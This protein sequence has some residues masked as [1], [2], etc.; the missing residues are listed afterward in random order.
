MKVKGTERAC[1]CFGYRS[2]RLGECLATAGLRRHGREARRAGAKWAYIWG[3]RRRDEG[4]EEAE[5]RAQENASGCDVE[6][7]G[8][9]CRL[10]SAFLCKS[11]EAH[12]TGGQV[13]I[14]SFPFARW[15][16]LSTAQS[17]GMVARSF[18]LARPPIAAL[19]SCAHRRVAMAHAAWCKRRSGNSADGGLTGGGGRF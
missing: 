10:L 5:V 15:V 9:C 13:P 2:E 19:F 1:V 6:S 14:I 18:Y 7:A 8:K 12:G 4:E 16:L 11:T 17:Q 3:G